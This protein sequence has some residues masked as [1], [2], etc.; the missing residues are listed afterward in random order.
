MNLQLKFI[1]LVTSSFG[2]CTS[3][4]IT[5]RFDLGTLSTSLSL[6]Y[7]LSALSKANL[8][9]AFI[10]QIYGYWFWKVKFSI[11]ATTQ[12]SV[13]V[14]PDLALGEGYHYLAP[15]AT[16]L[17]SSEI[18]LEIALI[19]DYNINPRPVLRKPGCHNH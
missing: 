5:Q 13:I 18:I 14:P 1:S 10:F 15:S 7:L 3:P 11:S 9:S 16:E 6:Q 19:H 4:D 8:P 12:L 17:D 2:I